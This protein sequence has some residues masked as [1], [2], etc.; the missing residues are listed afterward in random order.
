MIGTTNFVITTESD[1]PTT[2]NSSNYN[3]VEGERIPLV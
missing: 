1:G 2:D 3:D